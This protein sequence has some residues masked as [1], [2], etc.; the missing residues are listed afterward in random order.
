MLAAPMVEAVRA[1]AR[2]CRAVQAKLQ[3]SD[4][5]KKDDKSPVTVAD[6]ATQAI[7]AR[8]LADAFGDVP[9]VGEEDSKVFDGGPGAG[10]VDTVLSHVRTEWA[11]ASEAAMREAIDLGRGEGGASG[12][13]FTLDPIDGTKGVLRGGQYAIALA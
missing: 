10:L 3:A 7:I 1:G 11:D 8:R 12:R 2:V 5:I 4:S 6:L 9:L 13:F